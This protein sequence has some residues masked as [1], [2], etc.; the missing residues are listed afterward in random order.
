MNNYGAAVVLFV[1]ILSAGIWW[2]HYKYVDCLKVGHSKL[3]CVM[4]IGEK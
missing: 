1:V 2:Q 3:Y 4:S